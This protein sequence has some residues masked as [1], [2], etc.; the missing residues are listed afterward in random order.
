[1]FFLSHIL[2]EMTSSRMTIGSM[3]HKKLA[4]QL[5]GQL[6]CQNK[7]STFSSLFTVEFFHVALN[8]M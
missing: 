5:T 2:F 8:D 3:L 7:L 6:Q 1:M 4:A